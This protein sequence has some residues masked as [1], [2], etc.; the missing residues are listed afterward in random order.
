MWRR[1]ARLGGGWGPGLWVVCIRVCVCVCRSVRRSIIEAG[2]AGKVVGTRKKGGRTFQRGNQR[3]GNRRTGVEAAEALLSV[4]LLDAL[5][6]PRGPPWVRLHL[7]AAL[8]QLGGAQH[9]ALHPARHGA[10]D[11][12]LAVARLLPAA[13]LHH[14]LSGGRV[15]WCVRLGQERGGACMPIID[16]FHRS[17]RRTHARTAMASL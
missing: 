9:G 12:H 6:E 16:S 8:D 1:Q 13:V 4:H 15:W 7:Q 14:E 11:E 5:H 2:G 17:R 10:G 3:R